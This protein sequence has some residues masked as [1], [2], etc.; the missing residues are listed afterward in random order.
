MKLSEKIYDCRKKAGL[1]QEALAEQIG[2]SRQAVSK[3]ET[4][5]AV[6]EIGKLLLLAK[7]FGV[8]TDYLLSEE[9]PAPEPVQQH[10][11][12]WVDSIP[13][14]LGMLIRKYGWLLG[15]RLAV[16]GALFAFIGL[17][18]RRMS[19]GMFQDMGLGFSD[20][21]DLAFQLPAYT[22][23][24]PVYKLCTVIVVLGVV[25]MLAGVI[26]AVVLKKRSK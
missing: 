25:M 7:L 21:E 9:E 3:W 15:V 22:A 1:S 2:V 10:A 19:R 13:G 4:G 16:G 20:F 5:D 18:G 6:P 24:N 11:A 26:L 17:L 14:V 8:T 12:N 23:N